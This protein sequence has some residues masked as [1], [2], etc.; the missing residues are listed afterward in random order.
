M[1]KHVKVRIGLV[2]LAAALGAIIWGSAGQT[3][4]AQQNSARIEVVQLRPNFFLIAGAGGN[5]AVQV[6]Q[7]G[8]VLVNTGTQD[9]AQE[10]LAA[11]QKLTKEPIRY[12][13]NTSADADLVGGNAVLSKAGQNIYSLA[14]PGVNGRGDNPAG[15][16]AHENVVTAMRRLAGNASPLPSG[17]F[18]TETFVASNRR[19]MF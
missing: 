17:S 18:P 13:F 4:R 9:A 12:I 5:I 11:I 15:I 3:A 10:V 2:T 7:D 19:V 1:L 8:A 16:F 14:V 6:G